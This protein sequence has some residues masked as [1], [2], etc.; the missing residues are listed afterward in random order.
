MECILSA[1]T[2]SFPEEGAV[3]RTIDRVGGDR[4]VFGADLDVIVSTYGLGIYYEANLS[5]EKYQNA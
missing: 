5:Q 2:G 4:I 1:V 3:R